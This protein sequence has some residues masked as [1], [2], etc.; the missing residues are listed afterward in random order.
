[1]AD[2]CPAPG[3]DESVRRG[4][5]RHIA[6]DLRSLGEQCTCGANFWVILFGGSL[7]ALVAC[8][9]CMASFNI[10]ERLRNCGRDTSPGRSR[11]DTDPRYSG[12]DPDYRRRRGY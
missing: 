10:G 8:G 12:R 2:P 7:P 5:H 3:C 1:M 4:R 9:Q 11:V 6:H